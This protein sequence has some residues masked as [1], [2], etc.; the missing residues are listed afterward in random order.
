MMRGHAAG[1]GLSILRPTRNA[2][3]G[4]VVA[5]LTMLA[6]E[7][8]VSNLII[9]WCPR[10]E[11]CEETGRVLFALGLIVSFAVSVALGFVARDIAD[12]FAAR[13]LR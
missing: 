4:V 9:R 12:R 1:D 10:G 13:K 7:V 2:V 6:L 5:A 11:N 3:I 8:A